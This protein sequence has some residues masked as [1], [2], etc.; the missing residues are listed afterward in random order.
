[1]RKVRLGLWKVSFRLQYSVK[2]SV[3]FHTPNNFR[4]TA[5]LVTIATSYQQTIYLRFIRSVV[6]SRLIMLI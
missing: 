2:D 5:A 1:M 4:N 3:N 6:L